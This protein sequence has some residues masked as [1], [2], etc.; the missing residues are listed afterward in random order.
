MNKSA[1]KLRKNMKFSVSAASCR[2]EELQDKHQKK[3]CTRGT[4]LYKLLRS[5]NIFYLITTIFRVMLSVP[6][7]TE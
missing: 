7:V 5:N 3:G 2:F 1:E 6:S 4:A